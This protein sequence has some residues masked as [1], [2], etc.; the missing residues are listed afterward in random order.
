MTSARAIALDDELEEPPFAIALVC[1]ALRQFGRAARAQQ[2]Y[3]PNNP[4]HARAMDA[5]RESF[6]TLWAQTDS[7]KI[8][9]TDCDFRWWGHPVIEEP[10]R[11]SDSLPWLFYKDGIREL[12]MISGFEAE[13]LDILLGLVQRAR[14]AHSDGDD[15]LTLLWEHEFT[16]LQYKYVELGSDMG[17]GAQ[18]IVTTQHAPGERIISPRSVESVPEERLQTSAIARMDDY[19]TTLYFLDDREIDY[20]QR[21]VRND[22]S[23][24]LRTSVVASLLDTYEQETDPTVREEI[25]GNL[26]Q[27][28]LLM[29]SLMHFRTAAFIIR[30]SKV[31]AGRAKNIIDSER[32]RLL[33]LAGRLSEKEPLEQ[34]LTALEQV[35]LRPPQTDLHDLF[36]ELQP[37]ALQMLLGW[38]GRTAN[39]ELRVLLESAGSRMASSHTSELVRLIG[40]DD[41]VVVVE[42][43]RRAGSMKAAAAV[44]SLS[45]ILGQGPPELRLVAVAALAQIASPGAMQALDKAIEDEDSDVRV[46]A[47]KVIAANGHAPSVGRIEAQ[48]KKKEVREAPLAEKMAFFESYGMLSGDAGID[49]LD[50]ILNSRSFLGKRESAELRACAAVALGKIGSDTAIKALRGSAND[51][52]VIVRNAVSRAVR[53]G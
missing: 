7:I 50:G 2:L 38:I 14:L 37:G 1:D 20:L 23:S 24:D 11:T 9:I 49:F 42:A 12:T 10:G 28:L 15:L 46:A 25:A 30:E 31:S 29:L 3:L 19:D 4:M 6:R 47:V 44:Q 36:T 45:K 16:R 33:G 13:E 52:D 8:Q 39:P 17:A 27:L 35:S 26:D 48:L 34:L 32:E 53:G 22:F 21:E 41:P 51:S 18:P 5:V 43:I 40:S